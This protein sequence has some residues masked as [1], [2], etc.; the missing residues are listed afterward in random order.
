MPVGSTAST[1]AVGKPS[2][3]R[4]PRTSLGNGNVRN[5]SPHQS[6]GVQNS[7]QIAQQITTI[8]AVVAGVNLSQGHQHGNLSKISANA[9]TNA[10]MSPHTHHLSHPSQLPGGSTAQSNNAA[11]SPSVVAKMTSSLGGPAGSRP[12]LSDSHRTITSLLSS[13]PNCK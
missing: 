9:I 5:V 7:T 8:G 1:G 2:P 11:V 4:S 13:K 6:L 3:P 10:S 12:S